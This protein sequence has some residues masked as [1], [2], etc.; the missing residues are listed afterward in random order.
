MKTKLLMGLILTALIFAFSMPL[1]AEVKDNKSEW[2]GKEDINKEFPP[3]RLER[4]MSRL[5]EEDP[6][7]AA[8]LENLRNTDPEAFRTELRKV[9]RERFKDVMVGKNGKKDV[10]GERLRERADEYLQWLKTNYP[11]EADRLAELKKTNQNLYQRQLLVG[12]KKYA[13]IIEAEQENPE[14]AKILKEDLDLRNKTID[15]LVKIKA[16]ANDTEKQ[17][18]TAELEKIT[19]QR[20][21]IILKRKQMEYDRLQQ[22]IQRLQE[23][24][25]ENETKLQQWKQTKDE[26][27]KERVKELI[28]RTE[29]FDWDY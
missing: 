5:K 20:F 17:K 29:K 3:D 21:D 12:I 9:I 22:E 11:E 7:K 2:I 1:K 13:R 15:I 25:K 6:N 28:T 27:V 10:F 8:Q 14:L 26:R 4:I 18:L 24:V 16:A 23:Q 19:A